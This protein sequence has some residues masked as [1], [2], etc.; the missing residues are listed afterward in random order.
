[1]NLEI[2]NRL[3]KLRKENGYSQ[4]ELAEKLG[5]SRQAVSKWERAESSPDTDNLILLAELYNVSLDYL[6]KI[7]DE[8]ELKELKENQKEIAEEDDDDEDEEE[9]SRGV[10]N[11]ITSIIPIAIT[12]TYFIVSGLFDLWHP[13]W[14]LFLLIPVLESLVDCI[15]KKRI[16]HFAYPVLVAAVYL[17]IGF[18]HELWHPGWVIFLTIPLFYLIADLLD[19]LIVKK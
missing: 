14:I 13:A 5:I 2:A 10:K 6:L 9:S 16:S 19:K 18:L 17:Y 12:I 3:Q 11:V 7:S 4:E 8:N 15:Y 1:M